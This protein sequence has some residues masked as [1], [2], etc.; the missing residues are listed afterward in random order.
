[1]DRHAWDD[2]YRGREWLWTVDANRF[3]VQ[4][5]TGLTPGRALD[6]AAYTSILRFEKVKNTGN[7]RISSSDG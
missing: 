6:L 2:R 4:E 3:V 7:Q 1:M 5:V